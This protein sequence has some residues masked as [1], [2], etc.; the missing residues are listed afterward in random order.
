MFEGLK[1]FN[2]T[3][4]LAYKK[5]NISYVMDKELEK[6]LSDWFGKVYFE[7]VLY[8]VLELEFSD[9]NSKTWIYLDRIV[10]QEG[11]SFYWDFEPNVNSK[12][13]I[14]F[15]VGSGISADE[16]FERTERRII[17]SGNSGLDTYKKEYVCYGDLLDRN[18]CG[19]S[20][21][22]KEDK[23]IKILDGIKYVR[24][25]DEYELTIMVIKD[26]DEIILKCP[27]Y[28][29]EQLDNELELIEYLVNVIKKE[30]IN[31]DEVYH[32][33]RKIINGESSSFELNLYKNRKNISNYK[34]HQFTSFMDNSRSRKFHIFSNNDGNTTN[35][36]YSIPKKID[37]DGCGILLIEVNSGNY[38]F[39]LDIRN[40]NNREIVL[41]NEIVLREYL[42]NLEFPIKIEEVYKKVCELSILDAS[43]YNLVEL[44]VS[45]KNIATDLLSL[46][47]GKLNVFHYTRDGREVT[48]VRNG[49][50]TY[51]RGDKSS[52]VHIELDDNMVTKYEYLLEKPFAIDMDGIIPN[53]LQKEIM[54]AKNERVKTRKLVNDFIKNE[55]SE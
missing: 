12:D 46:D 45:Y 28:I 55:S 37:K 17:L 50:F 19:F 53:P 34:F 33:V 18:F 54:E 11:L 36:H 24:V 15:E 52:R 35:Y 10:T 7:D 3:L 2:K 16:L 23:I 4:K 47:K 26:N 5:R 43:K 32:K 9:I 44:K 8:R 14:D 31:L 38:K 39:I 29:R 41:D 49:Y 30:K 13:R 48:I 6:R 42:G 20:L 40:N 25:Q 27:R 21:D 22:K 1:I 51:K